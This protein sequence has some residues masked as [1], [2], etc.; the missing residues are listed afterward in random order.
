MGV[1]VDQSRHEQHIPGFQDLPGRPVP[2]VAI[3]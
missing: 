2:C 1:G 3:P